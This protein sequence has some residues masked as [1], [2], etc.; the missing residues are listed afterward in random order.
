VHSWLWAGLEYQHTPGARLAT[1]KGTDRII[2][3]KQFQII[4][5]HKL[6]FL[7]YRSVRRVSNQVLACLCIISLSESLILE[8]V[9]YRFDGSGCCRD[10]E[11]P[12]A[13]GRPVSNFAHNQ[14]DARH[15]S[16]SSVGMIG[17]VFVR[18]L[19]RFRQEQEAQL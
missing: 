9:A 3:H 2:S 12:L 10:A 8:K 6:W 5:R 17:R 18:R 4:D 14:P 15:T 19:C 13:C 11:I 1:L 7:E 16:S